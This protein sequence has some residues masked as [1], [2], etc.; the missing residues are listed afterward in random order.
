MSGSSR[1]LVL[2]ER[3]P[4]PRDLILMQMA[5]VPAHGSLENQAQVREG[6]IS[7]NQD[8]APDEGLDV[9]E[10]D[11]QPVLESAERFAA[12]RA[13]ARGEA[14]RRRAMATATRLAIEIWVYSRPGPCIHAGMSRVPCSTRQ[15]ST[16][17]VA[18]T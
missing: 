13:T 4:G 15:T 10:L 7:G 11:A 5:T 18:S 9:L 2:L 1:D 8:A 17:S 16:W 14:E 6:Y 3:R 12:L